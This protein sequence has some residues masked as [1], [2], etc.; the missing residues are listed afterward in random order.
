MIKINF[1][2]MGRNKKVI[3][4]EGFNR[5]DAESRCDVSILSIKF[6]LQKLTLIYRD[7]SRVYVYQDEGGLQLGSRWWA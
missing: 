1:A 6:T 3:L 4:L 7:T 5:L 2:N